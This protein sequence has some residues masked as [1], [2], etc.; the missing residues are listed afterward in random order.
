MAFIGKLGEIHTEHYI[1]WK[2]ENFFSIPED[3]GE[4]YFSSDFNFANESWSLAMAVQ[5]DF[6]KN[7]GIEFALH[8]IRSQ[9]SPPISVKC[10]LGLISANGMKDI[11]TNQIQTFNEKAYKCGVQRF[12]TKSELLERRQELVPDDVLTVFCIMR[13]PVSNKDLSKSN[14]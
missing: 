2:I 3:D 1:E 8:L 11:Q 14:L 4:S 7:T 6:I 9:F 13:Y 12:I 5:E 10:T